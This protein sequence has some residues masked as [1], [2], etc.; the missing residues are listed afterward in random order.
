MGQ[1]KIV[2]R[3]AASFLEQYTVAD[4]RALTEGK[5]TLSLITNEVGGVKDDCIITKVTDN[6]YYVVINAGCKEKDL[7]HFNYHL[8]SSEWNKKDVALHYN[9]DNSLIAVQGP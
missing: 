7:D 6:E 5:A 2:G 3:D 4:V 9:E 1:L 8:T